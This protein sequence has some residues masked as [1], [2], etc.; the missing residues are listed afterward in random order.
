MR[1][2]SSRN[3]SSNPSTSIWTSSASIWWAKLWCGSALAK[4]VPQRSRAAK[5]SPA[6]VVGD[7]CFFIILLGKNRQRERNLHPS[8]RPRKGLFC[9]WSSARFSGNSCRLAKFGALLGIFFWREG[10]LKAPLGRS[11]GG[12]K[13]GCFK[14]EPSWKMKRR[15]DFS[16]GKGI[17]CSDL[18]GVSRGAEELTCVFVSLLL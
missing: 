11:G 15:E 17:S 1:L 13:G 10:G 12:A 5:A 8:P 16:A 2:V 3:L 18:F 4:P 7:V 14:V 6:T 9:A